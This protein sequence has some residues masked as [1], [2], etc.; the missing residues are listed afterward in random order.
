LLIFTVYLVF[1][2]DFLQCAGRSA[3]PHGGEHRQPLLHRVR[4]P[5]GHSGR[6]GRRH[7][8]QG[9][10]TKQTPHKSAVCDWSTFSSGVYLSLVAGKISQDVRVRGGFPNTIFKGFFQKRYSLH[11]PKSKGLV[12]IL[13]QPPL[14]PPTLIKKKR[15]IFLIY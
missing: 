10:Q 5:G 13:K 8:R 3:V 2:L 6:R 1:H 7:S 14:D 15:K 9:A 12:L 4:L 11:P